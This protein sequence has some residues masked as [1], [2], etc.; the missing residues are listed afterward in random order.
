MFIR[1]FGPAVLCS[2]ERYESY[3]TVFRL[4]S[5]LSNRQAPS[6]D[7]CRRF[8]SLDTFKHIATGGF[9][10]DADTGNWVQAGP[11]VL[12][13][14]RQHPEHARLI[15]LKT[16]STQTPGKSDTRFAMYTRADLFVS[17]DVTHR[18]VP[19][20]SKQDP[21]G[22]LGWSQTLASKCGR[23]EDSPDVRYRYGKSVVSRSGDV[24]RV[25]N[26]LIYRLETAG[27][28]PRLAFARLRE[29]VVSESKPGYAF[30]IVVQLFD[31]E[32]KRHSK[33]ET[34]RLTLTDKL[35]LITPEVC[36]P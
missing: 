20:N 15:G 32:E 9:W 29:I 11:A 14:L 4:A 1:R 17:G 28:Q 2:T 27:T 5:V 12:L 10:L 8:S 26:T 25:D 7:I 36:F 16:E 34:P 23:T 13:Y 18:G 21:W 19:A 30:S 22:M 24:A 35:T 3:N 6:R 33:L 31:V